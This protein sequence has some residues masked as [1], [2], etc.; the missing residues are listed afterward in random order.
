MWQ[1]IGLIIIVGLGYVDSYCEQW[2]FDVFVDFILV[3]GCVVV[4]GCYYFLV[5]VVLFDNYCVGVLVG[6]YFVEFGYCWI[7]VVVG[8][9]EFNIVV[10]CI[11]GFR[12]GMDELGVELIV[13]LQVFIWEG[14]IVG[15]CEFFGW[16]FMVI[17]GFNDVMVIGIFSEL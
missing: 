7:G 14:G 15:V 10:D 5:D 11:V 16:G 1:W 8:L 9:F 4:I 6:W 12:E 17:V 13:V 2:M 3:G